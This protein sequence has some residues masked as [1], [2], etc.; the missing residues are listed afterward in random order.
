MRRVLGLTCVTVITACSVAGPNEED[1]DV[2]ISSTATPK[3]KPT[4]DSGTTD[5]GA[6]TGADTG[7]DAG[8]DAGADTGVDSGGGGSPEFIDACLLPG[9]TKVTFNPT[10]TES[11]ND[12]GVT[13]ALSLP[14]PFT[15]FGAAQSH[16]WVTTN[17][18]LGFGTTPG[19]SRFAQVTCPLPD[20]R[21]GATPILHVFT[22][23]LLTDI[24]G[25]GGVCYATTGTAPNRKFVVTWKNAFFYDTPG[26]TNATFAAILHEGTNVAKVVIERIDA[27]SADSPEFFESGQVAVIAKQAGASAVTYSCHQPIAPEGTVA[28]FNP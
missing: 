16:F 8:T 26:V 24:E 17:G 13:N 7:T 27:P 1:P 19:G 4:K 9:M 18:E 15:F 11:Y 20:S 3:A 14:F 5:T 10:G 28:T 23:D 25:D 21:Y 22:A 2:E 12:E 6:D